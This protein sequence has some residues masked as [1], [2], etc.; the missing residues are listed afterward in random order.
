[1]KRLIKR[2]WKKAAA[3]LTAGAVALTLAAPAPM[4][5][6]AVA[7]TSDTIGAIFTLGSMAAQISAVRRQVNQLNDTEEGRNQLYY[8]FQKEYGVNEDAYL[9][10]KLEKIMANLTAGVAAIDPSIKDKPYKWFISADK[11]I[12]AACGF[13][14][15]MMVNTGTFEQ[16]SNEDEIAAIVGH[17][18]GH[19]QKDHVKK[20]VLKGV[21]R[22]FVLTLAA[23]AAGGGIAPSL[24]A[25][26]ANIHMDAHSTKKNEWEA[27][28]MSFEYLKNTNYN[29]GAG[30]AV[31]QK[32]VELMGSGKRSGIE[33]FFNP[34]DHPNSEARRDNYIKKLAEYSGGHIDLKD[35]VITVNKQLFATPTWTDDMSGAER[36]CFVL[37][38]LAAAY[39]NGHAKSEAYASGNTIYLGAQPIMTVVS[40]DEP[41]QVLVDRLNANK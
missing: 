32:F 7:G 36:A 28:N 4:V 30:A 29:L 38:N 40:G 1:M 5:S 31:M 37:G 10:Q 22:S 41:I 19:G 9:N 24:A 17:E 39:H 14:H 20:G 18:M 16:I 6:T 12:N 8:E 11:T 3:L 15:V 25:S 26:V 33:N 27:D 23:A 13:G 2:I 35:G 21:N 34:S